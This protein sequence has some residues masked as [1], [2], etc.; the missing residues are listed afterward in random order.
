MN[1]T[2]KIKSFQETFLPKFCKHS[3]YYIKYVIS[4]TYPITQIKQED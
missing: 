4:G 2:T 1:G 3:P